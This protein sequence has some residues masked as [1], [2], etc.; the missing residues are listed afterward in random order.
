MVALFLILWCPSICL[1]VDRNDSQSQI[2]D[3]F[4]Y[5]MQGSL[6]Y[7]TAAQNG[8]SVISRGDSQAVKPVC[9]LTTQIAF[10]PDFIDYWMT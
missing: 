6:V 5:A 1:R 4:K 7:D 10:D 2:I 3:L 9:P 8:V